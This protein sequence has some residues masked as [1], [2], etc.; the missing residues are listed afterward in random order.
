MPEQIL[1]GVRIVDAG[2]LLAAPGAAA[3]LGDFGAEVIKI[4]QP[5]SGDPLRQ[6]PPFAEGQ[7]LTSKVTNRNKYSCTLD[8]GRARGRELFLRLIAASDAVVTNF[9]PP[10][11]RR[12]DIDYD[13]LTAVNPQ[14]VMLHLSGFGRTGP[15]ADRPAFARVVEAYTG[16]TYMTGHRDRPP[17]P[18]GY[19]IADALGTAFG[20][21]SLMLALYHKRVTGQGQLV[22]L[23]LY[24]ALAK[25]L[26]HVYIGYDQTGEIAERAGSVNPVAAPHDVYCFGDG[27]YVQ[28]PVTTQNMFDR[29]CGILEHPE[30]AEDPRF[31]TNADRVANRAA[32]DAIL[33]PLFKTMD[34]G[35][36]L[37]AAR[38]AGI[39]AN[40]INNAR[41]FVADAHVRERGTIAA[42]HDTNLGRDLLF[43]GVFPKLSKT[44]GRIDWPGH[45]LG[46]DNTY[47]YEH[48]LGLTPQETAQL[49]AD[50]II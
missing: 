4:E 12:W 3:L 40:R 18:S 17:L 1:E 14:L 13:A 11:L 28:L 38:A 50:N 15:Y 34:S 41:D 26:D 2:T 29:L 25:S 42:V 35:T 21:F 22:D 30:L 48:L 6:L 20:A 24:E 44:P 47:V 7:N 43:Q 45:E 23:S 39:A 5:G 32:L 16:L 49:H 31:R 36:F 27:T 9:R 37:K 8:L 46:Q 10:T 33:V 19:P